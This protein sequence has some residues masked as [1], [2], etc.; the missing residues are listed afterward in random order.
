MD[1]MQ[2]MAKVV[3]ATYLSLSYL[4]FTKGREEGFKL[5]YIILW[6]MMLGV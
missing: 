5:E 2:L 4:I 1:L 6:Y 3:L